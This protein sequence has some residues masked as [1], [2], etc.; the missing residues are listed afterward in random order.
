MKAQPC[1]QFAQSGSC[2]RGDN[3][4]YTHHVEQPMVSHTL[5]HH[6][7][8]DVASHLGGQALSSIAPL[9]YL[10]PLVNAVGHKH[11]YTV[12]TK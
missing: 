6:G 2:M 10:I 3:C 4:K 8:I 5:P 9:S 7:F 12:C 1:N 11:T